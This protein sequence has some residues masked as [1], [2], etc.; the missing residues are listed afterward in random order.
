MAL[1]SIDLIIN[2][3]IKRLPEDGSLVYKYSPLYNLKGEGVLEALELPAKVAGIDI[4]TPLD[5]DLSP[6]FDNSVNILVNDKKNPLKLINSRFYLDS[7]KSYRIAD[8]KG[9]L[10]T[11]IYSA[12]EFKSETGFIKPVKTI[13]S[14][15]FLGLAP[16]GILKV[17][18]YN[19]Y[20]KLAD[21]DGNES[22]FVAESG[23]VTCHIGTINDPKS[24]RGGQSNE[25]SEK[26]VRFKLSN[27]DPSYSYV[28]VYF[29]RKSGSPQSSFVEVVR[30]HN[31]F[32][33]DVGD[34]Y[35][36]ITGFET[37]EIL[38]ESVLNMRYAE[39][40]AVKSGENC[41]NI[42]FVGN[43]EKDYELFNTLQKYSLFI[44]PKLSSEQDVGNLDVDYKDITTSI[45][46]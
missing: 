21:S 40:D 16:G 19:F 38:D 33:L 17:G 12:D 20:F 36:T 44:T 27:L 15:E 7:S 41:Q 43:T 10:D 35:I 28:Y 26:A 30:I 22:D 42:T 11:N 4:N 34:T 31:K 5:L 29:S 8:R 13:A 14:L 37:Q 46:K 2:N 6:S 32:R 25:N 39:F 23:I 45:N 18:N 9:S 1:P 3:T 24:I